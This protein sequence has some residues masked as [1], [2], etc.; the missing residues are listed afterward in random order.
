MKFEES[1]PMPPEDKLTTIDA[2]LNEKQKR[3]GIKEDGKRRRE[4]AR[5]RIEELVKKTKKI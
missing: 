3:E 4:E 1:Q 5:K 2:E